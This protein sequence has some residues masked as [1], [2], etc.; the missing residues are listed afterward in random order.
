M[1][2]TGEAASKIFTKENLPW[3]RVRVPQQNNFAD[4]GVFILHYAELFL[5]QLPSPQDLTVVKVNYDLTFKRSIGSAL[6]RLEKK[7]E[8]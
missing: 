8:L 4:C 7:E 6:R 1:V 2:S 5:T 3:V